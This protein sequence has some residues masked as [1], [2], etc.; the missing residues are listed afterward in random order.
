[1]D[2]RSAE[3]LVSSAFNFPF[4][5]S[6]YSE[7]ISNIFK[8]TISINEIVIDEPDFKDFLQKINQYCEFTDEDGKKIHAI[9]VIVNE[10]VN[11]D[12]SRSLQRNFAI[13]YLKK[14]TCDSVLISFYNKLGED[15]RFHFTRK[16]KQH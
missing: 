5:Q 13:Y 6:K 12:K 4:D 7:L 2:K 10:K 9:E 3:N 8:N 14:Y 16:W 1:M 11:F 15:W